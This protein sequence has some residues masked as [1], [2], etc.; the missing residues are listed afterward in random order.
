MAKGFPSA[1]LASL[2]ANSLII[3]FENLIGGVGVELLVQKEQDN[4]L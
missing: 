3:V 2:A 4:V 1:P